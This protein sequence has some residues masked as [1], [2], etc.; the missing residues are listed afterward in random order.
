LVPVRIGC[1]F[2][3]AWYERRNDDRTFAARCAPMD[4]DEHAVQRALL[5]PRRNRQPAVPRFINWLAGLFRR[6]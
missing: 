4:A 1:R 6:T 2:E 5:L 3:P